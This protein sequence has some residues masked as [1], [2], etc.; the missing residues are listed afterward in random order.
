MTIHAAIE[1]LHLLHRLQ[2]VVHDHPLAP[3]DARSPQLR[4]R[5]PAELDLRQDTAGELEREK[6]HVLQGFAEVRPAARTHLHRHLAEPVD[7]DRYVVWP[8]V[9]QHAHV[10]LEQPEVDARGFDIVDRSD[11]TRVDQ[12]LHFADRWTEH[13]GMADHQ[14]QPIG[15]GQLHQLLRLIDGGR[16]RF[17]DEHMFL[18]FE[19][20]LH[21]RVV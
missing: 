9:P 18:R 20:A 2:V 19:R 16:Q 13:E 14:R 17:F 11:Q 1:D 5:Q 12:L 15:A 6:R 3:D 4:R 8:E 7:E 21:Q 10:L